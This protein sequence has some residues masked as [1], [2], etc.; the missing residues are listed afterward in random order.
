MLYAIKNN[1]KYSLK[2]KTVTK[3]WKNDFIPWTQP[4]LN[5]DGV[6][7]GDSFAVSSIPSTFNTYR[8]YYPFNP[9]G[10][11]GVY[12][13][14]AVIGNSGEYIIY[15]PEPLKITN[16][17]VQN[18]N[19]P[20]APRTVRS[21]RVLA[22]DDN[23]SWVELTT[24]TNNNALVALATWNIDLSNNTNSYKYYK[25][26]CRNSDSHIG[27]GKLT[28]TALQGGVIPASEEDYDFTTEEYAY[29][30]FIK[31]DVLK[32][33]NDDYLYDS[34]ERLLFIEE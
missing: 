21:G 25:L 5:A 8:A 22:S 9:N 29:F 15:N 30:A 28:L 16:I 34:N 6:L 18:R 10:I 17:L 13:G 19:E 12:T 32:D 23:S 24:F 7:G 33:S 2:A 20:N 1:N 3:Y 4:V 31:K 27:I 26:E 14:W 11:S